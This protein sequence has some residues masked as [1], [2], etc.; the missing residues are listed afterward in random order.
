[1]NILIDIFSGMLIGT[2]TGMGVGGGGLLVIYLTSVRGVSQ[3]DAQGCNLLFFIFAAAASIFLHNRL[4]RL[5]FRMIGTA[6]L[7]ALV[8]SQIGVRLTGILPEEA[9]RRIFGVMLVIA[10]IISIMRTVA[11][12]GVLFRHKR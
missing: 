8:G 2:L 12:G 11:S 10:G 4:R 5:D 7:F 3:L 6:A 1:M 9:I